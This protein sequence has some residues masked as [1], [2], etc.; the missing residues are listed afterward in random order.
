MWPNESGRDYEWMPFRGRK[1][2]RGASRP[3]FLCPMGERGAVWPRL[4]ACCMWIPL[5]QKCGS[6]EAHAPFL[7]NQ[8][9]TKGW[10]GP[11]SNCVLICIFAYMLRPR[12]I[13]TRARGGLRSGRRIGSVCLSC[14]L[15]LVCLTRGARSEGRGTS[16]GGKQGRGR[17]LRGE[18]SPESV[19]SRDPT[20]GTERPP[21][22]SPHPEQQQ[23]SP[24]RASTIPPIRAEIAPVTPSVPHPNRGADRQTRACAKHA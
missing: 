10:R 20:S 3:L 6:K 7:P 14:R 21:F 22:P 2:I 5:G 12:S 19:R 1:R 23:P 15:E 4:Q 24:S 11:A 16:R 8:W 13:K 18:S 9:L 17:G